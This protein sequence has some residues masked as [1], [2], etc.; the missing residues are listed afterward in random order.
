VVANRE[1]GQETH[2]LPKLKKICRKAG[3]TPAAATVYA[4]RHSFGAHLRMAGVPLANIA[5]L[6][7]HRDLATTQIY[8]KVQIDH[9]RDAVS[10]LGPLL[11]D[12]SLK[13]VTPGGSGASNAR[14]FLKEGDLVERIR[15]GWEAGIRTP[16]ERVRAACP[17]VERPPSRTGR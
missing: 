4:L 3:I 17:T 12:V 5:D 1:G 13:G 8:A 7:G 6:M 2:L 14:K 11:P 9:L 16:I 15:I 10:R